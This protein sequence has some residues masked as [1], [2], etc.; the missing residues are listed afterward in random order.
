MAPFEQ[1]LPETFLSRSRATAWG[2]EGP[3]SSLLLNP[4]G[5]GSPA[6]WLTLEEGMACK[7]PGVRESSPVTVVSM[8][9]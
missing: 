4:G 2:P 5:A 7:G 6:T 9:Q 3:A 8:C 1:C